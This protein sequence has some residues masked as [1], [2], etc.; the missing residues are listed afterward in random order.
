MSFISYLFYIIY[1]NIYIQQ[2]L[3]CNFILGKFLNKSILVVANTK[4]LQKYNNYSK[5][6]MNGITYIF[7]LILLLQSC[8]YIIF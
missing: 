6:L 8:S 1:Y 5:K 4:V 2:H 3:I 7:N